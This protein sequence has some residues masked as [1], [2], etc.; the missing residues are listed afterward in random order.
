VRES[1]ERLLDHPVA[2]CLEPAGGEGPAVGV[3]LAGEPPR[4]RVA[5]VDLRE[6][7][8]LARL[9]CPPGRPSRFRPVV[10]CAVQLDAP[11]LPQDRVVVAHLAP[12]AAAMRPVLLDDPRFPA[13]SSQA[14]G[15]AAAR[16]GTGA[17]LLAVDALDATG[18][19]VGR[20]VRSGI[21][22]MRFDGVSVGGH[23]RA[24]HGMG[25]GIGAGHWARDLDDAAFEAGYEPLMPGWVPP[26]LG[27][28]RPRVEPDAS[29]PAAPPAIVARWE[30][31]DG[32]RVL[33]R[34]APAPLASPEPG[35]PLARPVDIAGFAG[36]LRGGRGL[37]VLVWETPAR[38]FGVQVRGMVD[39]GGVAVRVA[40][41][42]AAPPG[43]E[44]G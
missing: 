29:Y 30:A 1:I 36:A 16:L 27:P 13:A 9:A 11:G 37:A 17:I 7:R 28:G 32:A 31:A 21:S 34:Q 26:G 42:I 43:P 8:V 44:V 2:C 5:W 6:E 40:R 18:E 15:V 33:L 24:T 3:S 19:A 14:E 22:E 39:P 41:S 20:L 10:A 38:A 35:G 12:T 25:A 4:L 23:L